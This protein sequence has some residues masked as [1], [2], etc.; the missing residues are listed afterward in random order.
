MFKYF[1]K[2]LDVS[3]AQEIFDIVKLIEDKERNSIQKYFKTFENFEKAASKVY[4]LQEKVI[5]NKKEFNQEYCD[6]LALIHW[7]LI[8]ILETDRY[9]DNLIRFEHK[10]FFKSFIHK[11]HRKLYERIFGI[12]DLIF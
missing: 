1:E 6:S 11:S 8:R 2:E 10:Y 7:C 5:K 3:K 12:K 4:F 9:F